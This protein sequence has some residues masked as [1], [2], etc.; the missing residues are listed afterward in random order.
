MPSLRAIG[1]DLDFLWAEMLM[2]R[3][4]QGPLGRRTGGLKGAISGVRVAADARSALTA[5][6]PS[7]AQDTQKRTSAGQGELRVR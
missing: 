1:P 7:A 3:P 5:R 4:P 2:H 6:G